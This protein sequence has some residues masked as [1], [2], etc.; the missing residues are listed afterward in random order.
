MNQAHYTKSHCTQRT[1]I[2]WK[3]LQR[4]AGNQLGEEI[5]GEGLANSSGWPDLNDVMCASDWDQY[6]DSDFNP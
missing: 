6:G 4:K 2:C 3:K 1:E 5:T